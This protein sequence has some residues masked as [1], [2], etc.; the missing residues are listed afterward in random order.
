MGAVSGAIR[1][2][3]SES[4]R[5]IVTADE[6]SFGQVNSVLSS[7]ARMLWPS[8]TAVHIAAATNC[9]VRAAEF[10]LAGERDWS[11]DALAAI[12]SEILK[13]H[14]MRNVKVAKRS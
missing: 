6:Q 5:A 3:A 13:R 4:K 1:V 8:K 2:E 14:S 10:Y 11:G 9:S 7:I 12:V